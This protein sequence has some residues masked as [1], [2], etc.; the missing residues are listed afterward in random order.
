[1]ILE[2]ILLIIMWGCLAIACIMIE[3]L[4]TNLI[5]IWFALGSIIG[6]ITSAFDIIW[7]WQ[8]ASFLIITIISLAIGYPLL[9][10]YLQHKSN[11]K[12]NIDALINQTAIMLTNYQ[13]NSDDI[14]SAKL[15]GKVWTVI[16]TD[17]DNF[18]KNEK[19]LVIAITG[20]KLI[21]KKQKGEK[22]SC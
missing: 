14:G 20:V 4:T 19:V 22:Q 5:T 7:Y 6:L 9:K 15:D 1:M 16:S 18:Q 13:G 2:N 12:T 17:N 11:F 8:I 3:L 10:H 21:I